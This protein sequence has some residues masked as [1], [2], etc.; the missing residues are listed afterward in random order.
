V[1]LAGADSW[2]RQSWPGSMAVPPPIR[3][4]PVPQRIG[5]TQRV[6]F[7]RLDDGFTLFVEVMV[8]TK[9]EKNNGKS[10]KKEAA[11]VP[12]RAGRMESLPRWMERFE[13]MFAEAWA[14][15]WPVLRLSEE[16]LPRV[17]PL[18]VYEEGGAV[19]VKAE[20]PG[21]KKEEI[22]VRV[23]GH[24]LTISGKKEKEE[25]IERKDYRRVERTAGMFSRTVT[26]PAEVELDKMTAAYKDGVLEIRAPKVPGAEP[27]GRKVEVS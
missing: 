7:D 15:L 6:D 8:V 3:C 23:S 2:R 5:W 11:I 24:V 19:V 13:N 20:L 21:M 10:Q 25:K 22:E 18:D 26:L 9:L 14:P 4:A 16:L 17:P 12:A 27:K 1:S